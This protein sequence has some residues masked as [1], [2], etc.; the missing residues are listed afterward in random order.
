MA[1]QILA[2]R[3]QE[4][5]LPES[6]FCRYNPR[7]PG[8]IRPG[9]AS[10][11]VLDLLASRPGQWLYRYQIIHIT[12]RTRKSIDWALIFLEGSG[13]V[14]KTPTRPSMRE[15]SAPCRFR[16]PSRK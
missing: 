6:R 10:A 16:V 4:N 15:Q 7:P 11:D 13:L 3:R 2:L 8:V 5:P 9:S 14:E 1:V 12:G